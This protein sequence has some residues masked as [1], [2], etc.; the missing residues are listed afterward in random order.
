MYGHWKQY[1]IQNYVADTIHSSVGNSL[2]SVETSLSI[3]DNNNEMW[4]KGHLLVML[5]CKE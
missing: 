3:A 4:N 2:P 1:G 5:S